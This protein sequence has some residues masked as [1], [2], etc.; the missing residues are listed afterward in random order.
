M[1]RASAAQAILAVINVLV[2]GMPATAG[3]VYKWVDADGITHFGESPPASAAGEVEVI[4]MA[5]IEPV[6]QPT[7]DYQST[8]DVAKSIE[9]S[10]LERERLRLEQRKLDADSRRR[11]PGAYSEQGTTRYYYPPY[12]GH[13]RKYP[14]HHYR[15][16]LSEERY[17]HPAYGY[18]PRHGGAPPTARANM[19]R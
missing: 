14:P 7:R 16:P 15:R 13:P 5:V 12:Y 11:Q 3:E 8:L 19:G 17:R 6:T 2:F 4:E 18:G 10:R 9:E 1:T